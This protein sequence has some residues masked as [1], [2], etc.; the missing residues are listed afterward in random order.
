[1]ANLI[2]FFPI[3][4]K[5]V[6]ELPSAS[7]PL[8]DG[9]TL[10]GIDAVD[11]T[12]NVKFTVQEV[13]NL[14]GSAAFKNTGILNGD[15]PLIGVNNKIDNVVLNQASQSLAGIIG[16]A[17][18]AEVFDKNAFKAVTAAALFNNIRLSSFSV[19]NSAGSLGQTIPAGITYNLLNQLLASNE[20]QSGE[21]IVNFKDINNVPQATI[22]DEVNNKF[23]FPSNLHTFNNVYT[24]YFFRIVGT[25]DIPST[26]SQT[27]KFNIRLRRVIDNSV[28]FTLDF[29][30]SDLAAATGVTFAGSILTFVNSE[31]DPFVLD[32]CYLDLLNETGSAT[33]ITLQSINIRIFRG[34]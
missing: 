3:L 17:T 10:L 8:A 28:I 23:L 26:A 7:T 20:T 16:L 14:F 32:G 18:D 4:A 12:N 1:M 25:F 31:A 19:G 15:V 22:L 27:T 21:F 9:I 33:S 30:R 24:P 29:A 5:K 11:P 6:S 13:K 2:E 34:V